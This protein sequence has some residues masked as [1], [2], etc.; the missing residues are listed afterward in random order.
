MSLDTVSYW[1]KSAPGREYEPAGDLECD[2]VVAGGGIIGV[3][4][5]L[6]LAREGATV[7]LLE[8]RRIGSGATGYTTAKLSSLHGMTYASLASKHDDDVARAYG[9]ANEEGLA[10]AA[11]FVDELAIDCD[12]RR[13]PNFTYTED[14][15]HVSE[16]RTRPP[17][18]ERRRA[19]GEPGDR[20]RRAALRDRRRGSL[21]R[22]GRVPPAP[23]PPRAR[24]G[25][26]RRP[27][28]R[29]TSARG[30]SPSTRA[31]PAPSAPRTGRR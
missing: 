7:A 12:F 4:T 9:E 6:L 31:I 24:R 23:L 29:S 17:T 8:A 21:R 20:G 28:A 25:G 11:R 14:P 1:A 22:P 10:M 13:K 30:S 27:A 2:V 16:L 5:A 19:A 18:A 3:T 15:G 26:A